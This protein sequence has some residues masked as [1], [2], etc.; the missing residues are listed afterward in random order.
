MTDRNDVPMPFLL[1][2]ED[3]ARRPHGRASTTWLTLML[4][5][6]KPASQ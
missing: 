2:P 6:L 5:E 4:P 1:V 3:A